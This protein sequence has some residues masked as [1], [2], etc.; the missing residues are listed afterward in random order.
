MVAFSQVL[1]GQ[2]LI[3][4]DSNCLEI[5]SLLVADAL[6]NVCGEKEV[7]SWLDNN[8]LLVGSLTIDSNGVLKKMT[9]VRDLRIGL[10]RSQKRKI[11]KYLQRNKQ[12]EFCIPMNSIDTFVQQSSDSINTFNQQRS[13]KCFLGFDFNGA[14]MYWMFYHGLEDNKETNKINILKKQLE[15]IKRITDLESS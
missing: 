15:R 14:S 13:G 2:S 11:F 5:N 3:S 6:L 1:H 10:S 9:I 4:Y 8:G 7:E 12:S